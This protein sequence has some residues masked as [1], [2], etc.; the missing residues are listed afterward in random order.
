MLHFPQWKVI[1]VIGIVVAGIV[2]ALP[3]VFP[4]AAMAEMPSWLPHHQVNL[5]LDL[6]GGAHLLYQLDEKEMADDWLNTVRGDVRET[7]RRT[8]IGYTDLSQDLPPRGLSVT[9][10][11][12]AGLAKPATERKKLAHP[13]G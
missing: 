10:R 12:P 9:I 5:G 3:N 6:Q 4:R 1:L 7:L 11:A 13:L 8:H 2:F